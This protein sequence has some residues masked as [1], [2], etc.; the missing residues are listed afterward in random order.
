[1]KTNI[2]AKQPKLFNIVNDVYVYIKY[3]L[4]TIVKNIT[5]HSHNTKK[6]L[7]KKFYRNLSD[8]RCIISTR[9][10]YQRCL[11]NDFFSDIQLLLMLKEIY[12]MKNSIS[13]G[14]IKAISL[15]KSIATT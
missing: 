9:R 1:M 3:T 7:N 5:S 12:F 15:E 4:S 2:K 11:K 10:V 13:F 8:V 6:K 14:F